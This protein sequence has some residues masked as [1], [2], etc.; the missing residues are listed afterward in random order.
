MVI[1][2]AGSFMMGSPDTEP[3]RSSDEGP[4]HSVT[5]ARPFAVG[6]YAVTFE[7]WDACVAAGGCTHKP[8]DQGWGRGRQPAI[9]VSWEDAQAYM[10]WLSKKTGN[11]YR[12]LS[13][14]E[15]EYA[16]RAGST[17]RYP[18]GQEPGSNNANFGGSGSR[19]SGKQ[20]APVGSFAPNAFGLHD[21]I[22]N[23]WEWTQ[24]CWHD[25]YESASADGRP[26]ENATDCGQRVVRGASWSGNPRN[27]R[28]ANRNRVEPG[29]RDG[30]LGFR[31]ARTL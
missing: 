13:E 7:E 30:N 1:V 20:T 5:I 27:I 2:P 17:T 14:A 10:A 9:N 24:D 11:A 29:L 28:V 21:M 16:A 18:W 26:W 4:Q 19:W 23:V 3:E 25:S 8:H 22:G 15:W 12:L 6:K 31:L